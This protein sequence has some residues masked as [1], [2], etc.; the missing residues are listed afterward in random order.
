MCNCGLMNIP[1]L[2]KNAKI[3]LVSATSIIEG[4]AHG[5]G[6]KHDAIAIAHLRRFAGRD[7]K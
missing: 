1:D 4:G 2:Q 3:T 7:G 6:K 5:F